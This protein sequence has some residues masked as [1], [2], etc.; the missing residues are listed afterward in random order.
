MPLKPLLNGPVAAC[1]RDA[2][3]E[4]LGQ[5]SLP[6]IPTTGMG[7]RLMGGNHTGD[8]SCEPYYAAIQDPGM[9]PST[10]GTWQRL[11]AAE[12]IAALRAVPK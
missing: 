8:G 9:F 6:G 1:S 2:C 10:A 3:P 7:C 11:A 5:L 4:W 12:A